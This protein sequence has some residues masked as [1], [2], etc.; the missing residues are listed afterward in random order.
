MGLEFSACD[1]SQSRSINNS[2]PLASWLCKLGKME[3]FVLS[4]LPN[5]YSSAHVAGMDYWERAMLYD[6][7]I[8]DAEAHTGEVWQE[9]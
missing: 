2:I 3:D 9:L 4:N 7:D 1:V 8:T 6:M 5:Y